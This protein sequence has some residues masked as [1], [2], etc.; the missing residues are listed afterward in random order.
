MYNAQRMMRKEKKNESLTYATYV[1]YKQVRNDS[2][3]TSYIRDEQ[4]A[5]KITKK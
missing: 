5:R 4:G 3:D 1:V 2:Q